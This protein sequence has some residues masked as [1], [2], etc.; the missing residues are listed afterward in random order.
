MAAPMLAAGQAILGDVA[1]NTLP[2]D[3][4][5]YGYKLIERAPDRIF[6]VS[7]SWGGTGTKTTLAAVVTEARKTISFLQ[8]MERQGRR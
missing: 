1:M 4:L 7:R 3:L 5:R 2:P 8:W 6:A